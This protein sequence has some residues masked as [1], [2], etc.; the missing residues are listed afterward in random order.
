MD[1]IIR[2]YRHTQSALFAFALNDD[3]L[4]SI[5]EY[6]IMRACIITATAAD[7][8]CFINSVLDTCKILAPPEEYQNADDE[9]KNSY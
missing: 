9:D 7:T 5:I 1:R 3:C 2:T 8:A 6:R 4:S